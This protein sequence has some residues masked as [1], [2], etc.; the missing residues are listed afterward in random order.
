MAPDKH[1]S[2][3]MGVTYQTLQEIDPA[4]KSLV[5]ASNAA[6]KK[7]Y[8]P[9][10]KFQVGAA[11]LLKDGTV[12]HGCNVENVSYGLSICAERTAAVKAISE[13]R[14][15]FEAIAV[16]AVME[17]HPV[18]PCG[19]CRQ[20][21]AEFNPNLQIYLHNPTTDQV[22]LTSLAHLLPMSFDQLKTQ[23]NV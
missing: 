10:S 23:L 8:C 2:G 20:F 12:V 17:S 22:V 5:D 7:A 13:G 4:I 3:D 14:T 6:R 21:L 15:D 1:S 18:S 16:C 19:A 9:Y 11:L